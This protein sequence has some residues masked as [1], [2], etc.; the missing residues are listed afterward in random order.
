[1]QVL[2]RAETQPM[3][4]SSDFDSGRR[5]PTGRPPV[6]VRDVAWSSSQPVMMSCA[7]EDRYSGGST[8]ARHEFKGLHQMGGRLE[9]AVEAER[10][11]EAEHHSSHTRSRPRRHVPGAWDLES[12]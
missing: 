1:M 6:V 12:D 10:V 2:D 3:M 4:M 9:D 5:P 8:I 7:W 11:A